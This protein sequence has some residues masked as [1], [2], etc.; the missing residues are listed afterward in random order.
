MKDSPLI[1]PRI[2]PTEL[3]SDFTSQRSGKKDSI[4]LINKLIF[5]LFS[6]NTIIVFLARKY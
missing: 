2:P 3:G 6:K 4:T 5:Y 1:F